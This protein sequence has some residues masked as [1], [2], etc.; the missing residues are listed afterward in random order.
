MVP[1]CVKLQTAKSSFVS[2]LARV[3]WVGSFLFIGGMTSFLIGLSWAGVQYEWASIQT[4]VPIIIGANA[5]VA[6]VAWEIFYAKEPMLRPWLFSSPSAI[7]AYACAFGQG[8]LVSYLLPTPQGSYLLTITTALLRTILHALLFQRCKVTWPY[9]MR[10]G[11]TSRDWIL[12]ARFDCCQ[13]PYHENRSLSLG[14]MAWLGHHC[15]VSGPLS[16]V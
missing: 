3:D 4:L 12:T 15:F 10:T 7:A 8:F 11:L 9:R 16:S 5:V 2:K 14:S 6:A 1:I 13:Y